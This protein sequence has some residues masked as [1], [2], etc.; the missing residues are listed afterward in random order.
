M[1]SVVTEYSKFNLQDAITASGHLKKSGFDRYD[2]NNDN[3]ARNWLMASV[4]ETLRKAISERPSDG[5]ASHWLRLI[6]L[7]ES[8]SYKQF[9]NIKEE[10][11]RLTVHQFPG[12][13]VKDSFQDKV[14]RIYQDPS[15]SDV[16]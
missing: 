13:S 4:D 7:I 5:V 1:I 16:G 9:T 12:Q 2:Q 15:S 6:H 3:S 10:I 14:L 8:T 11:E